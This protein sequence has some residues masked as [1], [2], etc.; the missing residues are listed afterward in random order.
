MTVPSTDGTHGTA[1]PPLP[2]PGADL[3]LPAPRSPGGPRLV[4]AAL[5]MLSLI[6]A[7]GCYLVFTAWLPSETKRYQDYAAAE[8]CPD[9]ASAEAWEDCLSTVSFTVESTKIKRGRSGSYQATLSGTLFW[10][11]TVAFGDQGP[12]LERLRPADRVTATV[13]RGQVMTV[14]KGD[15]RQST[16]EEPRNEPQMTVAIGTFLG[17][18]SRIS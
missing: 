14:S 4:G 12:L 2:P 3:H 8:P 9:R 16:S 15:V 1:G 11:G 5:I 10:N 17:A 6:P 13:W 18:V 7:L